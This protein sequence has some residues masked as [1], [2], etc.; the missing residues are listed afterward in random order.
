MQTFV[1]QLNDEQDDLARDLELIIDSSIP[2]EQNSPQ[3]AAPQGPQPNRT[4]Q[5]KPT[6]AAPSPDRLPQVLRS[7]RHE[8]Y[9]LCTGRTGAQ[10]F[11]ANL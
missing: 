2:E 5:S 10:Q 9:S 7:Y 11:Y 8:Q 3:P 1:L 6:G 4:S